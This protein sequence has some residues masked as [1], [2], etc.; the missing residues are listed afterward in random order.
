VT[1]S[2]GVA[3]DIKED[4]TIDQTSPAAPIFDNTNIKV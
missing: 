3:G 1:I 2:H 4:E